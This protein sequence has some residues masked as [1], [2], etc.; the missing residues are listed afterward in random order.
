MNSAPLKAWIVQQFVPDITPADLDDDY[1]LIDSGVVDSL[2][3]LRLISW[4]CDAN[5]IPLDEVPITPDNFRSVNAIRAFV[6]S[7]AQSQASPAATG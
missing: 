5:G 2:R 6:E 7:S 3:L 1:D 4:V